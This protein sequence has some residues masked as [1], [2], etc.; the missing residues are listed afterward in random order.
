[1][2]SDIRVIRVWAN[3]DANLSNRVAIEID[4]TDDWALVHAVI[5]I[6]VSPSVMPKSSLSAVGATSHALLILL[7]CI[8]TLRTNNNTCIVYFLSEQVLTHW[9]CRYTSPRRIISKKGRWAI[10]N[11]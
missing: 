2:V 9:T 10:R 5:S 6:V 1:M 11:T 4:V 7:R 8:S 3:I